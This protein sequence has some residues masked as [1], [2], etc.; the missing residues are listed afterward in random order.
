MTIA[1]NWYNEL[2]SMMVISVS[3]SMLQGTYQSFVGNAQGTYQLQGTYN[4]VP[5]SG[6]TSQAASWAVAWNNA[7][8]NS[9]AATAW[10]GQYQVD[11]GQEQI[12]A[13][14]FMTSETSP[15]NDWQ[16]TLAGKDVFTRTQPSAEMIAAARK[17]LAPSHPCDA[18]HAETAVKD[19]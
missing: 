10:S 11:D 17:R 2:G 8:G 3:G 9:H 6:S 4:P 18:A 16:S 5:Y 12:S 13:L 1:G 15:Q 14:W 7:H 19:V